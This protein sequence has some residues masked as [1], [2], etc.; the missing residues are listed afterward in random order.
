MFNLIF[1][2]ILCLFSLVLF[3]GGCVTNIDNEIAQEISKLPEEID[4]NFHV[5]PILSDKCFSCHGP[6]S[7]KRKANLRLDLDKK[8]AGNI[9]Q[10]VLTFKDA[11]SEIPHRLLS[12]DPK[13][14]MPPPESHLMLSDQE[15]AIILKW[16]DQGAEYKPHWSLIPLSKV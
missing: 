14:K 13:I 4:Y 7:N 1:N 11:K 10:L 8:L 5:K 12:Q 2:K 3:T 15:I 6:D 9:N 16:M